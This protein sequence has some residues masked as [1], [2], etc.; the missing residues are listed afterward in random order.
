MVCIYGHIDRLM[1]R[2]K[3][4]FLA[5]SCLFHCAIP[6][7]LNHSFLHYLINLFRTQLICKRCIRF[8]FVLC[9]EG[10]LQIPCHMGVDSLFSIFLHTR[11]YGSVY[12]QTI[13]IYIVWLS[14]LLAMFVTPSIER[15]SLPS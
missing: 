2:R 6:V 12:L 3:Y 5:K 7:A 9:I 4:L 13:C 1:E 11:V 14:I 15:I 8:L 10:R